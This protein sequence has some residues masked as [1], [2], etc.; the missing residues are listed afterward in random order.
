MKDKYKSTSKLMSLALRHDPS[1]INITLDENGWTSIQSLLEGLGK[2]GHPLAMGE[3]VDLV[4]SNDKKR[5]TF[6][7]AGDRIRANQGHSVEVEL[8]LDE[9]EPPYTL[10]HGTVAKFLEG[11]KDKGLLKMSRQHIHLSANKDTA[12][13]VGQ[14]RGKPVILK[15][16]TYQMYKDGHKF[17]CSQNGVWLTEHVPSE[18]IQHG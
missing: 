10:Y 6:N 15:I 13:N 7:E 9:Q 8:Q 5:F 3:L 11:I 12:V 17:Y 2:K 16:N 18:Y 1:V 14:R 4:E